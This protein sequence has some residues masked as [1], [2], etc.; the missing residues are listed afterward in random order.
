ITANLINLFGNY[1]LVF[2]HWGFPAL[3]VVGSGIATAISRTYLASVLM[4]FLFWHDARNHTEL[5][6]ASLRP[7]LARIRRLIGLGLPAALQLPAEWG[8]FPAFPSLIS[9]RGAIPLASHQI[10]LNTVVFPYM[11]PPGISSAAAV[12]VGQAIGRRDPLGARN[13]GIT[14]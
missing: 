6:R 4:A 11:V 12:R 13:A 10:A 5:R 2:G 9:R 1:L 3:G 14:A 7:D 8:L